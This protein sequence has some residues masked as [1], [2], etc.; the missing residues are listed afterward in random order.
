MDKEKLLQEHKN[1][2]ESLLEKTAFVYS[3]AFY[4][5]DEF[6]KQKHINAKK[7][8]EIHVSSLC[9]LLWCNQM[10]QCDITSLLMMNLMSNAFG[11]FQGNNL[12]NM[13]VLSETDFEDNGKEGV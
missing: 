8:A 10:P 9:N 6:E 1:A 7:T 12:R 2:L 5:L 3:E 11:G 13:E 4:S